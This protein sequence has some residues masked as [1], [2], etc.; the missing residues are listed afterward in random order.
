MLNRRDMSVLESIEN[1][2]CLKDRSVTIS[3]IAISV[4]LS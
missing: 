4:L 1:V 2:Y 3:V